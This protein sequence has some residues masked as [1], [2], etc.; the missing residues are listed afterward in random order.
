MENID[1]GRPNFK[2]TYFNARNNPALK[3]GRIS[4]AAQRKLEWTLFYAVLVLFDLFF[5]Y[6]AFQAAYAARFLLNLSIFK[7]TTLTSMA[8]YDRY[9]LIVLPIWVLIF[10]GLG[11]YSRRNLLGGTQEY[12]KLFTATT[13]GMLFNLA[14]RFTFSDELILARGWLILAWIFTFLFTAIGRFIVRRGVYQMRTA[15]FFQEPALLIGLN[16]EG[17]LLAEQLNHNKT[18]GIRIIGYLCHATEGCD[19]DS[20]ITYLGELRELDTIINKFGVNV[21]IMTTSALSKE[22]T[23]LVFRNYGTRKDIDLRLSSGLYEIITTGMTVKEEGL[24]PLVVVNKVRLTGTDQVLKYL[25]DIGIASIALLFLAPIFLM[26][27][28]AIRLDSP[29]PLIYRRR[30]LGVNGEEFDAFK[31]R[32]MDQRS[33]EML[34]ND[35]ELLNEYREN[36][37]IKN[38]PRITR[39]GKFLRKT[40]LDELPQLINVLRNEMSIVGPRMITPQ[41]LTKYDQWDINLTTVKPGITGLW[42]VRGRSDVS[43][44]ERVRLDMYYIRNWT[45]WIDIQIITQTIPAVLFRRGAY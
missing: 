16:E 40:S 27:A 41:E 20:Q 6:M 43:Y 39:V 18:A 19:F 17:L 37:K 45:I 10:A 34:N 30:V 23:L 24:V 14:A 31:F 13:F 12:S 42:Q 28:L 33:E 21:L 29:G 38:D 3:I 35:P 7:P 8:Y 2:N 9:M 4:S 44:A 25:L 5:T 32:T 26:I 11:L 22:Q 36:Y 1:P 15:G